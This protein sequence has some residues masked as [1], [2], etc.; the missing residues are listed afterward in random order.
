MRGETSKLGCEWG[1]K[2]VNLDDNKRRNTS[3][4]FNT[5]INEKHIKKSQ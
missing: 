4:R 5:K 2:Q 3:T 1:E